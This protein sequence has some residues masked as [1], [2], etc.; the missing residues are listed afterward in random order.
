MDLETYWK[1]LRPQQAEKPAKP[2]GKSW[3]LRAAIVRAATQTEEGLATQFEGI[4]PKIVTHVATTTL[5]LF[6]EA[7][8]DE[9]HEGDAVS[10]IGVV[11]SGSDLTDHELKGFVQALPASLLERICATPSP[12][13][14]GLQA[15]IAIE[16]HRRKGQV[17]DYT[18]SRDPVDGKLKVTFRPAGVLGGTIDFKL[19]ETFEGAPEPGVTK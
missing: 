9:L 10:L 2:K 13:A 5:R 1:R 8:Y 15:L 19:E 14:S 3:D 18:F 4:D 16:N 6:L 7:W 12:E 11:L 17:A